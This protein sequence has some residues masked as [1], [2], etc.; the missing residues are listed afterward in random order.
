MKKKAKKVLS[1]VLALS[2][3]LS[4]LCFNASA[5]SSYTFNSKTFQTGDFEDTDDPFDVYDNGHWDDRYLELSKATSNFGDLNTASSS[6][7]GDGVSY[8]KG[9]QYYDYDIHGDFPATYWTIDDYKFDAESLVVT[10]GDTVTLTGDLEIPI[11]VKDGGTLIVNVSQT[12]T[13]YGDGGTLVVDGYDND[14]A[15]IHITAF[16]EIRGEFAS[17]TT[18]T[19]NTVTND[20]VVLVEETTIKGGSNWVKETNGYNL[21]VEDGTTTVAA[22]YVDTGDPYYVSNVAH[23]NDYRYTTLTVKGGTVT[24][25]GL[26]WNVYL[27]DGTLNFGKYYNA[28]V[29]NG[30]FYGIEDTHRYCGAI[31]GG[32]YDTATT[33]GTLNWGNVVLVAQDGDYSYVNDKYSL[34]STSVAKAQVS[35]VFQKVTT[36]AFNDNQWL[37]LCGDTY[38]IDGSNWVFPGRSNSHSLKVGATETVYIYATDHTNRMLEDLTILTGGKAEILGLQDDYTV[39]TNE[40]DS[41]HVAAEAGHS[42]EITGK[43]FG[44][45]DDTA[46]GTLIISDLTHTDVIYD[47][48]ADHLTQVTE[49][50]NVATPTIKG[51]FASVE[52]TTIDG[53]EDEESGSTTGGDENTTI[54]NTSNKTLSGIGGHVIVCKNDSGDAPENV[55]LTGKVKDITVEAGTVSITGTVDELIVNGGTVTLDEGA[56][57]KK[58]IT[59]NGGDVVMKNGSKIEDLDITADRDAVTLNGGTFTMENGAEI[60]LARHTGHDVA[61]RAIEN[62]DGKVDLKGGTITI[63]GGTNT[64]AVCNHEDMVIGTVNGALS[65]QPKI[66]LDYG[67]AVKNDTADAKT[68][69]YGI[70]VKITNESA[71]N[72]GI[73]APVGLMLILAGKENPDLNTAPTQTVDVTVNNGTAV[74]IGD[75][76]TWSIAGPYKSARFTA[77]SSVTAGQGTALYTASST[78]PVTLTSVPTTAIGST[79]ATTAFVE[80]QPLSCGVFSGAMVYE[81]AAEK[82]FY[83]LIPAKNFVVFSDATH[84]NDDWGSETYYEDDKTIIVDM[85]WAL[86]HAA[87]QSNKTFKM[88]NVDADSAVSTI[89]LDEYLFWGAVKDEDLDV[90]GSLTLDL[91]GKTLTKNNTNF[92]D[93][94]LIEVSGTLTVNDTTGGTINA[95]DLDDAILVTGT[96]TVNSGTITTT[97]ADG[98]DNSGNLTVNDGTIT[99]GTNGINTAGT[100][101]VKGGN[102]NANNEHVAINVTGGTTTV[103]ANTTH[104]IGAV[105]V[106]NGAFKLKSTTTGVTSTI[107]KLTQTGGI[108]TIGPDAAPA[109]AAPDAVVE[110]ASTISGGTLTQN[111]GTFQGGLTQSNA[112]STVYLNAGSILGNVGYVRADSVTGNQNNVKKGFVFSKISTAVPNEYLDDLLDD[113][114]SQQLTFKDSNNVEMGG[115]FIRNHSALSASTDVEDEQMAVV[116]T[117]ADPGDD[118]AANFTV[119]DRSFHEI[120]VNKDANVTV[121]DGIT[122]DSDTVLRGGTL[123]VNNNK[124]AK[125]DITAADNY[126]IKYVEKN[127]CQTDNPDHVARTAA[128]DIGAAANQKNYTADYTTPITADQDLY[129]AS[130]AERVITVNVTHSAYG[131]VEY[132]YLNS[133]NGDADYTGEG[134]HTVTGS[135]VYVADGNSV[136]FTMTAADGNHL[137]SFSGGTL[138]SGGPHNGT[139]AATYKMSNVTAGGTLAIDF[140]N[141][142]TSAI[143]NN[144]SYTLYLNGTAAEKTVDLDARVN[145][146]NP[147]YSINDDG[148]HDNPDWVSS[149]TAVATVDANGVVTAVA[150]GTATITYYGQLNTTPTATPVTP[151]CTITVTNHV[152]GGGGGGGAVAPATYTITCETGVKADVKSSAEGKTITLTVSDGYENVVVKDA[153]GNEIKVTNNTFKMPASNVTVSV[154]KKGVATTYDKCDKGEACVL[155]AFNDLDAWRWYHDGIH[156]CLDNGVMNGLGNGEFTPTASTTR[157]MIFTILARLDGETITSTGNEWYTDGQAWSVKAGVSD[158]TNPTGNINREQLAAMLYRYAKLKGYD[159]SVGEDTNILS[160]DDAFSVSEYAVG[161]MQWAVGAGIINGD[162][163][164]LKPTTGATRAE[165]ATMLMRFCETVVK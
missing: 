25:S 142:T 138:T 133:A 39:I 32:I 135:K 82:T 52:G 69:I 98:I 5:A 61:L 161:A 113:T 42:F 120:H 140:C 37:D 64:V 106:S 121:S 50:P 145:A 79:T 4:M 99:G 116:G 102:V 127:A 27:T 139:A 157:G 62:K 58:T 1:L 47:S 59:I 33:G 22:T 48:H 131:T 10:G 159:V 128:N 87:T 65:S 49:V 9:K 156:Y 72:I 104:D 163:N 123:F 51:T 63:T 92:A 77:N 146:D 149:D 129:V 17:V 148:A 101:T 84:N 154:S 152:Y 45:A 43:I 53:S 14:N 7:P 103:D 164:N 11:Y 88:Y 160:Y 100:T 15:G 95:V 34:S 143:L 60:T 115:F 23:G 90:S 54:V 96:L 108:V 126:R 74:K 151:T 89:Y 73:N 13:I 16:A 165:V 150:T 3:V 35:G 57:V 44:D 40:A 111:A 38:I 153:K 70:D 114:N 107:W 76:A 55:K 12:G 158:G 112:S 91:N 20:Y 162:N 24:A 86:R 68:Y 93:T 130:A 78:T 2:M 118:L 136:K 117:L 30:T 155:K 75:A 66:T 144:S 147:C 71:S 122:T 94:Q 8:F 83:D 67:T 119:V 110:A 137:H 85:E 134:K 132:Q 97:G 105:T 21:T 125:L 46:G 36:D 41:L 19:H 80:N 6:Q 124:P 26:Y 18:R 141:R 28:G 56:W 81:N 31:R 109:A 29:L